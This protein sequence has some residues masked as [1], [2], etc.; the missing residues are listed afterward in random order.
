V[1]EA[2]DPF[3]RRLDILSGADDGAGTAR[4]AVQALVPGLERCHKP[5]HF[6]TEGITISIYFGAL[7]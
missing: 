4:G 1:I 7:P 2:E 6:A 3:Q 5:R